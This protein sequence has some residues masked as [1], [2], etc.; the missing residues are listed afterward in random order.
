MK[1]IAILGALLVSSAAM[2]QTNPPRSTAGGEGP[3]PNE[4]ICRSQG[5]T[6]SRLGGTRVCMTRSQWEAQRRDTQSS[7]E[8]AQT[9]RVHKPTG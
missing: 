5:E 8:R 2:A 9:N 3:D 1:K 6:G 7:V 4:R